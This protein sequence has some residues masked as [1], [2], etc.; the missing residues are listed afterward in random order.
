[1]WAAKLAND[2]LN[3]QIQKIHSRDHH[4]EI[5]AKKLKRTSTRNSK[6]DDAKAQH[7]FA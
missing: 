2:F 3:F 6:Q 7:F 4:L 5:N 1:M